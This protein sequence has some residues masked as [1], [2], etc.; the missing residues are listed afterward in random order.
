MRTIRVNEFLVKN[1]LA[2]VEQLEATSLD[3]ASVR[4][5]NAFVKAEAEACRK[6][7]GIWMENKRP[8]IWMENKRPEHSSS[9]SKPFYLIKHFSSRLLTKC[10]NTLSYY[11]K[12][13]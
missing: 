13:K 4:F 2:R 3:S 11:L 9:I 8:G 6:R 12:R 1:G 7:K 5:L 10:K